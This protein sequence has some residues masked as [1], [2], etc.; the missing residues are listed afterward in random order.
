MNLPARYWHPDENAPDAP[1][2]SHDDKL[3]CVRQLL[4][5]WGLYHETVDEAFHALRHR[6]E[7]DKLIA[8]VD[9]DNLE[10]ARLDC[11]DLGEWLEAIANPLPA[12]MRRQCG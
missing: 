8:E 6:P 3:W 11:S 5:D 10:L 7:M 1:E 2:L 9:E 4:P 12:L